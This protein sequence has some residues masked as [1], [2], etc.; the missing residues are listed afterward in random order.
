LIIL[1]LDDEDFNT[2]AP[3]IEGSFLPL[4]LLPPSVSTNSG[5]EEKDLTQPP[6]SLQGR[7]GSMEIILELRRQRE[8]V[9]REVCSETLPLT[10]PAQ[11]QKDEGESR[12]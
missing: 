5:E 3:G 11:K 6:N 2:A 1:I 9:M 4:S 10:F 8:E 7:E 12:P